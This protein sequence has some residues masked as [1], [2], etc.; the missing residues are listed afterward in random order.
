MSDLQQRIDFIVE[1]DKLKSVYRRGLI[2]SDNNRRENTAEH[3]WHVALMALV[4]KDYASEHVDISKV[5]EMLL[6]HDMV[7]IY[8]GDT[9]AFADQATLAQQNSKELQ[10]LEK[11]FA[12]LPENDA[13]KMKNLWLEFEKNKSPEAKFA[14]ALE[15]SIP[16]YQNMVNEGGSW[17]QNNTSSEQ[18]LKRNE[19]LKDIAP[20]LW[21]YVVEQVQIA[22]DEG[23][24][25]AGN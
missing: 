17:A 20:K 10:A 3:S 13:N 21:D 16:V 14:K 12:L 15:K 4:F 8:A 2:K 23:W 25:K 22:V 24:L 18:V 19:M 7:E 11:V 1:A 6:I 5:V 9:Y